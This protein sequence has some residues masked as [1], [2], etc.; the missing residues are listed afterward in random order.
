MNKMVNNI[1]LLFFFLFISCNSKIKLN[2]NKNFN[3]SLI[4]YIPYYLKVY[5]ADSLYIV[6][7]YD[8][9]YHILDSLFVNFKPLNTEKYKEYE[10]YISCAYVLNKKMDFKREF[11]KS[12]EFYGTNP[13]YI[14]YDSLLKRAYKESSIT[15][16]EA[17][18]AVKKYRDKLRFDLRETVKEICRDDQ[19]IR[20]GSTVYNEKINTVDSINQLKLIKIF[21]ENG[22]PS[23]KLIG[24][25]YI[26]SVNINLRFVFLHTRHDFRLNFLLPKILEEVKK[27]N[28]YPE[29]YSES[30]DRYLE[31]VQG[32]KQL[33]GS[34]KL[35][36]QKENVEFVNKA[37]IDSIRRSIGLPSLNYNKWRQKEKYG[38]VP[39]N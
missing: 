5:E 12:I 2:D 13:R 10:T 36:R 24:E 21:S 35:K 39:Y 8:K 18:E 32:G 33:Y 37:K 20:K 23:E 30:Y 29:M 4:N 34:Y 15:N 25:F 22:F 14:K 19:E 38:I 3:S 17:E 27:G 1:I 6:K 9:C 7:N 26:D 28:A 16:Q 31:E 11:L